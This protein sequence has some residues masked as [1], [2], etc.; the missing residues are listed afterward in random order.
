MKKIKPFISTKELFILLLFLLIYIPKLYANSEYP[1]I[2]KIKNNAGI[3][4]AGKVY[5]LG[6]K[7]RI[8]IVRKISK[9][10]SLKKVAEAIIIIARN[11][12][13]GIKII[14]QTNGVCKIG[15]LAIPANT[16]NQ[17]MSSHDKKERLSK[18]RRNFDTTLICGYQGNSSAKIGSLIGFSLGNNFGW[19]IDCKFN[20]LIGNDNSS[21]YYENISVYQAEEIFQDY[22]IG[23]TQVRVAANIGIIKPISPNF[24]YYLGLGAYVFATEYLYYDKFHI[25]GDYGHYWIPS[26]IDNE[27][28]NC[29]FGL[30]T[31]LENFYFQTGFDTCFKELTFG[32]GFTL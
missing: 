25:L 23:E 4:N 19:F 2:I 14:S 27:G 18:P 1:S 16:W 9:N 17:L 32:I 22:R 31:F 6:E 28:I 15:D 20:T 24:A 21:S 13:C 7:D 29:C 26:G 12:R 8:I 30:L 5:G 3:I 10:D 11:N